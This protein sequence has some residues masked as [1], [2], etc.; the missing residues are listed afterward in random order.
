MGLCSL[1]IGQ[2]IKK[3]ATDIS[4]K[5]NTFHMCRDFSYNI[6]KRHSL[7]LFDV[8]NACIK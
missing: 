1:N 8:R 6:R 7:V 2:L 4:C 5:L 3:E